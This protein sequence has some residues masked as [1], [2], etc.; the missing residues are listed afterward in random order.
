MLKVE[1]TKNQD[2]N[3]SK[4]VSQCSLI[5]NSNMVK[6]FSFKTLKSLDDDILQ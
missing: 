4:K 1:E 2:L 3:Y 6:L 5:S